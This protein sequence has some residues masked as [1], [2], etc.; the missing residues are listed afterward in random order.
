MRRQSNFVP[1]FKAV[2]PGGAAATPAVSNPAS[3]SSSRKSLGYGFSRA[4]TYSVEFGRS[5]SHYI[6]ASAKATMPDKWYVVDPRRSLVVGWDFYMVVLL[7]FTI[8]V[9]P[10]EVCFLS[11]DLIPTWLLVVNYFVDSSFFTDLLLNFNR[12]TFDETTGIPVS[13]VKILRKQYLRGYFFV[14]FVSCLPF[15]QL[16]IL[17]GAGEADGEALK[18]LRLLKLVRLAKLIKMINSQELMQRAQEFF[19]FRHGTRR[20]LRFIFISMFISHFMACG[21]HVVA[22]IEEP[23]FDGESDIFTV[24]EDGNIAHLN[25]ITGYFQDYGQE[26]SYYAKYVVA[27]YL[28][29]MTVTTVGYGDVQPKTTGER[30]YLIIAMLFGASMQAYV[31]GSICGIISNLNQT[32]GEFN[33]VMDALNAFISENKVDPE[34]ARRLRSFIR[35][36]KSTKYNFRKWQTVLQL[37]SPKLQEEAA[38]SV[39]TKW[40]SKIEIFDNA[41]KGMIVRIAFTLKTISFSP[42]ESIVKCGKRIDRLYI[43]TRGLVFMDGRIQGQN[44]VIGGEMLHSKYSMHQATSMTFVDTNT[45]DYTDFQMILDKYPDVRRRLKRRVVQSICRRNVVRFAKAVNTM[46]DYS[47]Q[48]MRDSGS[49]AEAW[50]KILAHP[51]LSSFS[52]EGRIAIVRK[53]LDGTIELN[54]LI[55]VVCLIQRAFKRYKERK[56][57]RILAESEAMS[58]YH[59]KE[60]IKESEEQ[61]TRQ[62]QELKE[63]VQ[64]LSEQNYKLFSELL[65][66]HKFA[67][68]A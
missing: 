50:S 44:T 32:S 53:S 67:K 19:E 48:T 43:V 14:D 12:M 54:R 61:R 45:I 18:I 27:L 65:Y 46:R 1:G 42:F 13:D 31:V 29:V 2:G 62:F 39:N 34:L 58:L 47:K 56:R 36:S 63:R 6:K 8:I 51:D 22:R 57:Q 20:L 49:E 38:L 28:S 21:W 11:S 25:W 66:Q 9:T 60:M 59:I 30:V 52:Q 55:R 7:L 10:F 68:T 26:P 33:Q 3:S 41:P 4:R 17:F 35:Y 15:D 24:D 23:D 16:A 37:M 5:L 64:R 40:M